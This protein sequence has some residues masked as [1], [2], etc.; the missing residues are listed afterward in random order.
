MKSTTPRDPK[1]DILLSPGNAALILIDYQPPQVST[2]D[3]MDRQP[4]MEI[5]NIVALCK[6][7]KTVWPAHHSFHRQRQ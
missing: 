7:A 3:S 2:V 5:N 4:L 1:K 6:T